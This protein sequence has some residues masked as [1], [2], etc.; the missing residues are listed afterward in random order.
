MTNFVLLVFY[1]VFAFGVAYVL[2]HARI[3]LPI[4]SYLA[5]KGRLAEWFVELI[6]CPACISFW[7]G[8]PFGFF[9][10]SEHNF[11]I[12]LAWSFYTVGSSFLLGHF[13]GLIENG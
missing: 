13:T 9:I 12:G 5:S 6:E 1:T 11:W 10:V 4:R 3:S 7:L 8:F 2:G